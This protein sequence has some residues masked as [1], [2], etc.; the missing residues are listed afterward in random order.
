MRNA[1]APTSTTCGDFAATHPPLFIEA[2]EPLEADH[3]LRVIESKFGLLHCTEVQKTLFGTQQ[4][5]GNASV[6]WANYAAT[7]PTD[8]QV[9]WTE[10]RSAFCAHHIP[11]GVMR[12]KRQE[13]MDVK[14]GGWSMHDYSKLLNHR[15][16]YAPNQV[17]TDG[18]KKDHFMIGHSTK[19]Q[20]HMALNMGGSFPEFVSNVII[21]AEAIHTHK[22]AKERKVVV[23]PSGSAPPRYCAVYHHGSTYLPH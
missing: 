6:W 13:F 3:W 8:Y 12:K 1:S 7:R 23:A 17:D 11:A 2:R 15:A 21:T 14:Q 4:L 20:E 19:L 18:K 10:F 22:E 5:R 9:S 16:Q